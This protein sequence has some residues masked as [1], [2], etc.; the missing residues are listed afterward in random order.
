MLRTESHQ[1][2]F[3]AGLNT[4]QGT[5]CEGYFLST[6]CWFVHVRLAVP[7]VDTRLTERYGTNRCILVEIEQLV[8]VQTDTIQAISVEKY[9][10]HGSNQSRR[11]FQTK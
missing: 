3:V 8:L 4:R 2:R 9:N 6:R 11:K 1:S 5:V 10:R 7:Y